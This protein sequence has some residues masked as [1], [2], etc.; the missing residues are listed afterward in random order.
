MLLNMRKSL[1][2]IMLLQFSLVAADVYKTVDEDG[3]IIFTDKPSGDAEK[4]EL[5]ELQTIE[6]PNPAKYRPE[7]DRNDKK[8]GSGDRNIYNT[9][10]VTNPADGSGLRNNAGNVTITV[11]VEPTLRPGHR[12]VLTMDGEEISNGNSLSTSL[13]NVDRG[14]HNIAA[15]IVDENDKVL[16]SVTSSFSLLRVHR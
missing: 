5:Q 3:N 13:Q 12:L 1:F 16:K 6:N 14:T 8:G 11:S 10:I 2:L 4:I 7:P 9:L 15:S